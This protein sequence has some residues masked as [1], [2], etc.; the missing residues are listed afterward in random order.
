MW[1]G[2]YRF[3]LML[4]NHNFAR[5]LDGFT[6]LS[7]RFGE[8]AIDLYISVIDLKRYFDGALTHRFEL[9]IRECCSDVCI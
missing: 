2:D 4:S 5:F 9:W 6:A 3:E 7:D 8:T 1:A